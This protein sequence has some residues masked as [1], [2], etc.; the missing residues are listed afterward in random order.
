MEN[1]RKVRTVVS[2]WAVCGE[3]NVVL[4]SESNE[5][6]L[7]K[8]RVCLNLIDSL[9]NGFSNVSIYIDG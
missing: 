3:M 4:L 1:T 5:I 6:I 2:E 8:K 9:R 7:G